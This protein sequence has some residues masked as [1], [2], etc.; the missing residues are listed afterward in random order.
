[1]VLINDCHWMMRLLDWASLCSWFSLVW[2]DCLGTMM[3]L[4]LLLSRTRR[5]VV[6][7]TW[8]FIIDHDN[9]AHVPDFM[10]TECV[11]GRMQ[12]CFELMCRNWQEVIR[13]HR[14]HGHLNNRTRLLNLETKYIPHKH[15]KRYFLAVSCDACRAVTGKRETK[16][17][18]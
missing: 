5:T 9:E 4:M 8:D 16:R 18:R 6:H 2:Y 7:P 11:E 3:V 13:L 12:Q 10:S 1:M 15:V 17:L 14:A